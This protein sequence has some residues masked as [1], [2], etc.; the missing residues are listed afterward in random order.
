MRWR[1][2]RPWRPAWREVPP[3][4]CHT[5][6]VLDVDQVGFVWNPVAGIQHLRLGD[7][8]RMR[9]PDGRQ[10]GPDHLPC[11]VGCCALVVG[12]PRKIY[13][14]GWGVDMYWGDLNDLVQE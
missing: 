11:T 8:T 1:D 14:E 9:A 12:K 10:T 4:R 7:I 2:W 6:E 5:F 3:E 13:P